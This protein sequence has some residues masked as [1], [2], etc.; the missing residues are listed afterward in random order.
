MNWLDIGLPSF[1]LSVP[2]L[3][4]LFI[5]SFPPLFGVCVFLQRPWEPPSLARLFPKTE[6]PACL[7]SHGL[8]EKFATAR[9]KVPKRKPTCVNAFSSRD[10]CALRACK[11]CKIYLSVFAQGGGNTDVHCPIGLPIYPTSARCC[12][13]LVFSFYLT[14]GPAMRLLFVK[15]KKKQ[16]RWFNFFCSISK[17]CFI[18]SSHKKQNDVDRGPNTLP[19]YTVRT[20]LI[21]VQ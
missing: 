11:L 5:S 19:L 15:V 10:T 2:R 7:R 4:F 16:S 13:L 12:R 8:H 6:A 14:A 17:F 9:K 18:V 21:F 1:P 20:A 3:C